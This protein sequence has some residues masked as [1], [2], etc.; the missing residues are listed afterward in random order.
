MTLVEGVVAVLVLSLVVIIAWRVFTTAAKSAEL[1]AWHTK[2]QQQLRNGLKL[3][4]DDL[5]HA[6]YPSIVGPTAVQ[7]TKAG[8][9]F[10]F[11]KGKVDCAGGAAD[12]PLL[13]F[14]ICKPKRQGFDAVTDAKNPGLEIHATLATKGNTVVYKKVGA[15][16]PDAPVLN[17]DRV[18]FDEVDYIALDGPASAPA[19]TSTTCSI[20]IKTIHKFWKQSGV[21]E[22]TM[23]KVEVDLSAG[24]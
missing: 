8:R 11:H 7:I 17:C 1:S 4:R 21:V 5:A 2:C 20:Q 23:P 14:Y 12:T 16:G 6:S 9:G 24:L 3:L 15:T 22:Q 10:K 18:L 19:E 13:D